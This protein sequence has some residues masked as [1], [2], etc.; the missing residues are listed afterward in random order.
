MLEIVSGRKINGTYYL[1]GPMKLVGY[2]CRLN[3]IFI[4]K[5]NKL[6]DICWLQ[7]WELWREGRS[8]ELM[9]STPVES[10]FVLQILRWIHVNLLCVQEFATNRPTMSDVISMLTN[11]TMSLPAPKQ[12]AFSAQTN[13][14]SSERK[15]CSPSITIS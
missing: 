10:Y 2:V 6:W 11:E 12:I 14:P 1:E 9:D 4:F 5:E 3:L 15:S 8:L 13:L 7:A